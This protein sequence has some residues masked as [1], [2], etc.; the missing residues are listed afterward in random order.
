MRHDTCSPIPTEVAPWLIRMI[1]LSLYFCLCRHPSLCMHS[2]QL[3]S[4][5]S[6][7]LDLF[8]SATVLEHIVHCEVEQDDEEDSNGNSD[9]SDSG[10]HE[11]S[12][13]RLLRCSVGF[14]LPLSF[15]LFLLQALHNVLSH[16]LTL[17][18]LYFL[19][20]LFILLSFLFLLFIF[21]FIPW[22]AHSRVMKHQV[23]GVWCRSSAEDRQH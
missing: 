19:F 9:E 4:S 7:G 20:L 8:R 3:Y 6:I 23:L 15:Y 5:L 16:S 1:L 21:T 22:F 12:D 18:T 13:G 14:L 10:W 11:H 17:F 2:I